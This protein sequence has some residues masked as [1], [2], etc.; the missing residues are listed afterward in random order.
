MLL[1]IIC[2]VLTGKIGFTA[3]LSLITGFE[4]FSLCRDMNHSN[5]KV[6]R[7]RVEGGKMFDD[8]LF[9]FFFNSW[10]GSC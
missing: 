1:N 3:A 6:G 4:V 2:V 7:L 10:I 9:F 8:F 5:P